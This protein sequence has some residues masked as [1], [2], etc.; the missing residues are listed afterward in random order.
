MIILDTTTKS[1]QIKLGGSVTT[2][3]LFW[4]S[5][6]VDITSTTFVP[7]SSDGVSNNATAVTII[8]SPAASTQ[9]QLKQLTVYNDDTATAT[10][11]IN[12]NDNATIRTLF[13]VALNAGYHLVINADGNLA[14]YDNDGVLQTAGGGGSGTPN[15]TSSTGIVAQ[16]ASTSY[17][18]RTITGT[19][20][21]IDVSNGSGVSGDPTISIDSGYVGQSSLT[22]LGTITSG[23]WHGT[24]IAVANGG[25]GVTASDPIIQRVSTLLGT[26]A[27]GTT[28]FPATSSIPTS[29][30]GDQYITQ[31]ITPKNTGNILTITAILHIS[32]SG[33]S[34]MSA[35]IFQD[36]TT[37]ALASCAQQSNTSTGIEQIIIRFTMTAGTTSS[38]TFKL[39]AG[40]TAGTTTINGSSGGVIHGGVM[41]SSLTI[42]E[43]TS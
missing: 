31:A 18:A 12:Y 3:Q 14:V 7:I 4:V 24:T 34:L 20:G 15:L 1:L 10:V 37:N 33:T 27:T 22:T 11:I 29:T 35:A 43:T 9:R 17:S 23:T 28:A 36:S 42:V 41:Y 19:S 40:G 6:Y 39:R 13:D 26:V 38:T 8:P 32:N 2:S 25:T 21:Q 5:S 30:N 16:T